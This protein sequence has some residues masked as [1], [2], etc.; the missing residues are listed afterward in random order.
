MIEKDLGYALEMAGE[1]PLPIVAATRDVLNRAIAAGLGDEN[2]T[3]V[4]KL[5]RG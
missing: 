2:V 5:Y 4:S 1:V 3:A